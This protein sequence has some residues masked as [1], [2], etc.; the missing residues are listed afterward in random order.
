MTPTDTDRQDDISTIEID[1]RN[2]STIVPELA[3]DDMDVTE[4]QLRQLDHTLG[5]M[6]EVESKLDDMLSNL[7]KMITDLECGGVPETQSS[8]GSDQD[9]K[10]QQNER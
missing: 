6:T 3:N 8:Q 5:M 2:L 9:G 7:D 10:R 4:Q 1:I